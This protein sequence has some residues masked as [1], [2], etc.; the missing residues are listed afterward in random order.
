MVLVGA[1]LVASTSIYAQQESEAQ[2]EE[3][4]V[5][6]KKAQELYKTGKN[7]TLLTQEDLKAYRGKEL[8][9][10]LQEV[11]GIQ[12]TGAQNN[13][14]EPKSPKIR[15]G[16][17]SNILILL[18]GVPLRDV[19]GNDYTAMDL[20]MIP[21]EGIS[22]IEILNGSSSVLYGSNAT[23]S[24]I[25][26]RTN[27]SY[28]SPIQGKVA[29]NGGSFST[30]GQSVNV[31]GKI[32]GWSYDLSGSNEKSEGISSAMGEDFDKDGRERQSGTARVRYTD[33]K[34]GLYAEGGIQNH[35]H[36]YDLG[37]FADSENRGKD[38]QRYVGLGG[39]LNYK[40]G[41]LLVRTRWS[42]TE[43]LLQNKV[44]GAYQDEYFYQGENQFIELL[45]HYTF[46]PNASLSAGVS[47]EKQ[48]MGAKALPWGGEEM[49]ETLSE[50]ETKNT[51]FDAFV[52]G[53]FSL[54]QLHLDAG[55][56]FTEHS[57]FG[58]H[59]V[60]NV[61]PYYLIDSGDNYFKA[62]YSL[63]T[64]FIAPT[65]YQSYG[66][67]PYTRGNEDLK[68]ETNLSHEIN[69][70]YGK[71]DQSLLLTGAFYL[72]NE[73]DVFAY[74]SGEDFVGQ[75]VNVDENKVKGFEL[76]AEYQI[77]EPLRIGANYS[78]VEKD[79]AL[80]RL[81]LPKHRANSFLE[82]AL[83][84]KTSLRLTHQWVSKRSDSYYDNQSFE[85]KNVQLDPY[86]LFGLHVNQKIADKL[87]GYLSIGNLFN[88]PYTDVIGYNTLPR[89]YTIGI[90]FQF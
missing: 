1:L 45:N 27:R 25:N 2:I 18:D 8:S 68:P 61:N 65:L 29:V 57:K 9:E 79:N 7:V 58:S 6:S 30:F 44:E 42:D 13:P 84:T 5:A 71:K 70:S 88:T 51:S 35:L 83:P 53:Q 49:E 38:L 56:R 34:F 3:V 10:V 55:L 28:N 26:I 40:D 36:Q 90:E 85:V 75:F 43:R 39:N 63:A 66:T 31:G 67:P 19:T 12:I 74:V 81:R 80:T 87:E 4:S 72:R 64:A 54:N 33:E 23:V 16:K 20:R 73:K 60:Y 37:A 32:N 48:A 47:Y 22:S 89:N 15:G 77:V 69:L 82:L 50:K 17:L 62:G 41:Q 59:V 11:S 78:F 76:V 86:H 21:L 46:S 24:V 52:L 14:Q